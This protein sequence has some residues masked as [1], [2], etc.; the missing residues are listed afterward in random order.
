MSDPTTELRGLWE[1][2]ADAQ[3]RG[4]SPLYECISRAVA[5]DG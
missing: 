3:C 1:W 5:H 2:F 4:Y